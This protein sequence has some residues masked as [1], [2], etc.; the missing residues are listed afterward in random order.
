LVPHGSS[1][2]QSTADS[3]RLDSELGALLA[4]GKSI[5]SEGNQLLDSVLMDDET[6]HMKRE[7]PTGERD[8]DDAGLDI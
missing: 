7:H 2:Q 1:L 8:D 3:R 6:G 4:D 5:L